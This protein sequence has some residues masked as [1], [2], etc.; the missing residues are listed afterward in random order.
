MSDNPVGNICSVALLAC[1]D[2]CAG[3]TT[4]YASNR[5]HLVSPSYMKSDADIMTL[6][7]RSW[8]HCDCCTDS[9]SSQCPWCRSC[10]GDGDLPNRDDDSETGEDE[11]EESGSQRG[12]VS[13]VVVSNAV[14]GKRAIRW[15][16][17]I[18]DYSDPERAPLLGAE[19]TSQ[20]PRKKPVNSRTKRRSIAVSSQPTPTPRPSITPHPS[21]PSS[22][23]LTTDES[24]NSKSATS[25]GETT[26]TQKD[27]WFP[28]PFSFRTLI[29][30]KSFSASGSG[31]AGA[32]ISTP[33]GRT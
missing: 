1:F 2:V 6:T 20:S 5:A 27:S 11:P 24:K 29:W 17:H 26:Q 15:Q 30:S 32:L 21:S 13:A 16:D 19:S 4:D 8:T 23:S 14:A 12:I 22:K 3:F 10:C 7:G 33:T 18:N 31:N 28:L 9:C 25:G